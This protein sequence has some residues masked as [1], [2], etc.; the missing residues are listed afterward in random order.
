MIAY[1]VLIKTYFPVD[2]HCMVGDVPFGC[3]MFTGIIIIIAL[4]IIIIIIIIIEIFMCYCVSKYNYIL[5]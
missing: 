3:L 5:K 1:P 4:I 2:S